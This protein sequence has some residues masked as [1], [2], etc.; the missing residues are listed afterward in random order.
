M[1][2]PG[3]GPLSPEA[4]RLLD[5][6][7]PTRGLPPEVAARVGAQ[8]AV[9]SARPPPPRLSLLGTA[10][11]GVSG[12]LLLG[13]L[14]ASLSPSQSPAEPG[15]GEA[16]SPASPERTVAPPTAPSDAPTVSPAPTGPEPERTA[17]PPEPELGASPPRPSP[18]WMQAE[19]RRPAT[20]R[21]A[22][23]RTTF[24]AELELLHR[25]RDA[26]PADPSEARRL[27][28]EHA[29][30]FPAGQ[31]ADM[32]AYVLLLVLAAEGAD[33]DLRS[34]AARFV[35]RHPTSALRREVEALSERHATGPR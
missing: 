17:P 7:E 12:I 21:P 24:S 16:T 2:E 4:R 35:R 25:A 3:L 22:A 18:R 13:M 20:V 19:P 14:A 30:R 9:L 29:A 6:A 11:A 26:L 34:A 28:L 5:L 10:S 1:S 31:L 8:V 15:A 27:A 23:P 32:R 33:R